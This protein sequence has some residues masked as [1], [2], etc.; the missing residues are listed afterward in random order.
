M[1]G[2]GADRQFAVVLDNLL[3]QTK[4]RCTVGQSLMSNKF[5]F[6]DGREVIL[7]VTEVA[8]LPPGPVTSG[9]KHPLFFGLPARLK[10]ARRAAQLSRS[11]TETLAGVSNGLLVYIEEA[12]QGK[13]PPR[14][15]TVEQIAR[16]L[17]VSACH[18][19]YGEE[20]PL[21]FE[22]KRASSARPDRGAQP[23]EGYR[24]LPARLRQAREARG[25]SRRA[26]GE[27]SGT[28][29]QTVANIEDGRTVPSVERVERLAH[30]LLIAPCWLAF[31][32]GVGPDAE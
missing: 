13:R 12:P 8:L 2:S 32:L 20:G 17:G 10:K 14:I 5:Y 6:S 28:T 15:D 29:G 3:Q 4:L 19:A 24:G 25:L 7:G 31:G 16:A 22:Q 21:I 30:T 9:R 27:T 23:E 26:L 1:E 18:L 11:R